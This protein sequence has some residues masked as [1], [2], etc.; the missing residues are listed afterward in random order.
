MKVDFLQSHLPWDSTAFY[1]RK[2]KASLVRTQ[3]FFVWAGP[4]EWEWDT[5]T[6]PVVRGEE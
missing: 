5:R 2:L 4:V 6:S 3:G 1:C